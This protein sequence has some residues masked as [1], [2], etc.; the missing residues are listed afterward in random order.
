MKMQLAALS[1]V[2]KKYILIGSALLVFIYL[3]LNFVLK[4]QTQGLARAGPQIAKLKSNLDNLD[5]D[6]GRMRDLKKKQAGQAQ[7]SGVQAKALVLESEVDQLLEDVSGVAKAN[8]ADIISLE[9][10]PHK[11]EAAQA[12]KFLPL[13]VNLNLSC[14]Y[15]DLGRFIDALE[16]GRDFISVAGLVILPGKKDIRLQEV[17]LAL[18]TYVAK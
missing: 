14:S 12:A 8:H 11:D 2:N 1:K 13:L 6:L 7:S 16:A 17:K 18:K 9:K 3:D 4:A 5:R 10:K 15:H